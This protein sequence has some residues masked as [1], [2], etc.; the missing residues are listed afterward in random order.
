MSA[1]WPGS[2]RGHLAARGQAG[3]LVLRL[4]FGAGRGRDRIRGQASP[5][6]D[7]PSARSIRRRVAAPSGRMPD[8]AEGRGRP[9]WTTTPWTLPASL[10]VALGAE[11]DYVLVE[12][13][14]RTAAPLA[15]AGRATCREAVARYASACG[16]CANGRHRRRVARW[17][18][19]VP[20]RVLRPR[21]AAGPRRARLGGGGHRRGAHRAGPRPG[22]LRRSASAT[23]CWTV[24]P[25]TRSAR[26][27]V[28]PARA[29]DRAVRRRHLE[30][31]RRMC[32]G[33]ARHG[34][35]CARRARPQ[36]PALLAAQDARSLPRHA[37]V[38]HLDGAGGLRATRWRRSKAV[39]WMPDWGE[40]RIA[41][42]STGRPTGAS[43]ASAPGACR[44]RCSST[45]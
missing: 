14:A 35:C 13:P 19:C 38:V 8:G 31:Q 29:R 23:A 43:R 21:D 9:I 39:R 7:V 40:A 32:R 17:S 4:R 5:A 18:T 2:S 36:L 33:A 12:G 6:V 26:D 24:R 11:L 20:A 45:A 25:A 42:W 3:A 16:T 22:G 1:R 37:A 41:A 15:G 10:A 28:L 44:S 30:G 27:G 34:T